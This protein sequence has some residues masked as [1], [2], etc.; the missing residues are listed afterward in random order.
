MARWENICFLPSPFPLCVEGLMCG[1]ALSLC[2][3]GSVKIFWATFF[4]FRPGDELLFNED[5][6][7]SFDISNLRYESYYN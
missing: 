6:K 7:I 4:V 3:K 5:L 2:E 1:A